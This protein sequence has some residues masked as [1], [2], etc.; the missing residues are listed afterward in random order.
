MVWMVFPR[1]EDD[2]PMIGGVGEEGSGGMS[3]LTI[4]VLVRM[5]N[6]TLIKYCMVQMVKGM[7]LTRDDLTLLKKRGIDLGNLGID[8]GGGELP[9]GE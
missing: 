5:D 6:P 9:R 1:V 8:C 3:E 4:S 7:Q 2:Q